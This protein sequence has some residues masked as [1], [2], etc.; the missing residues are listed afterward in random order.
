MRP[1]TLVGPVVLDDLG[2]LL[3]CLPNVVL[4]SR[5]QQILDE[6]GSLIP[7]LLVKGHPDR[8]GD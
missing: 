2:P 7:A 5:R 1:P 6:N 3:R 8:V 4:F